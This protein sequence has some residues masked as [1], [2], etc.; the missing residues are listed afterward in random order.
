MYMAFGL[1]GF[2]IGILLIIVGIFLA[3]FFPMTYQHQTEKFGVVGVVMG[4]IFL[5]VG[6]LLVFIP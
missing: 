6:G 5:I 2:G 1:A 4:L 3:F